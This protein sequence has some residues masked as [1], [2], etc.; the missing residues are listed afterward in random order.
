MLSRGV[1]QTDIV[2]FWIADIKRNLSS[3][4]ILRSDIDF[5]MILKQSRS[6]FVSTFHN[7]MFSPEAA[8]KRSGLRS[9]SNVI[10]V[11]GE[12]STGV[13]LIFWNCSR[14][15][16]FTVLSVDPF[17]RAKFCGLN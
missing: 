14:S 3:L 11:I 16:Y 7:L 4:A 12:L 17:A 10:F 6:L 2:L 1:Y 9:S 15:Q 13:T 8:N 5:G